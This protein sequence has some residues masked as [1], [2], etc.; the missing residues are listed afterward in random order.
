MPFSSDYDLSKEIKKLRESRDSQDAAQSS[1]KTVFE[2]YPV[3]T[4]KI[5]GSRTLA[6]PVVTIQETGG[7]RII[8]RDRPFR[9]GVKCDDTGS[10][11]R[12]WSIQAIFD[13]SLTVDDSPTSIGEPGIK[14]INGNTPL[15]PD[16]LNEILESFDLYHDNAGTLV[17]PTV[18]KVKARLED[19]TRDEKPEEWDCATIR[20]VFVEDNEDSVDASSYTY[21]SVSGNGVLLGETMEFSSQSDG[22][23]DQDMMNL[24]ELVA[25]LEGLAN[26]PDQFAAD[27]DQQVGIAIGAANR[28]NRTFSQPKVPGR[29]ILLDP[30]SSVTQRKLEETKEIAS[31]AKHNYKKKTKV[32]TV[33]FGV[34]MSLVS[35]ASEMSQD[36]ET[37]LALNYQLEDPFYIRPNTGVK[38]TSNEPTS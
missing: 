18:G 4:W 37:L 35:V 5:G 26:M 29:D 3:A 21:S 15:Y 20:F 34:P 31:D 32:I 17:V 13:N 8:R 7:S 30:E 33:M 9:R 27:I 1:A 28:I 38:I 11:P 36:I 24:N 6:F 12:V 22:G 10:K 16:I 19:Y 23:W 2:T 14:N 25:N